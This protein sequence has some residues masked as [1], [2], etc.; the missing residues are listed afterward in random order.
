MTKGLDYTRIEKVDLQTL[1][2][3]IWGEL[4]F[5]VVQPVKRVYRARLED[6]SFQELN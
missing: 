1:L 3:I 4:F 2:G 5:V 6:S